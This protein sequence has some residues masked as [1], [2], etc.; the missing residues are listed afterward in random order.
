MHSFYMFF[1]SDITVDLQKEVPISQKFISP[2]QSYSATSGSELRTYQLLKCNEDLKYLCEPQV[3]ISVNRN[4]MDQTDFNYNNVSTYRAAES[5]DWSDI[6]EVSAGSKV[7]LRN[8]SSK[9]TFDW[10]LLTSRGS[11]CEWVGGKLGLYQCSVEFITTPPPSIAS[12]TV[13]H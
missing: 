6:V 12:S 5:K 9:A 8:S 1:N 2:D 4:K 10:V 13:T 3:E 11:S 7:L